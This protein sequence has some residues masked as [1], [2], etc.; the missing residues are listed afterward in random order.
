MKSASDPNL[1]SGLIMRL[2]SGFYVVET[3]QGLV[4][5]KVRGLLKRGPRIGDIVAV[6]DQVKIKL[7]PEG[8]GVIEEVEERHH[9]LERLAPTARGVYRQILLANPEQ[10][11]LVFACTQPSPSLR[12]LDRFLVIAEKQEIPPLIVV[13][14]VDLLGFEAA[15]N[16]FSI[17]GDIGYRVLFA[18]AL[19]GMGI[20]KLRQFL[21]GKLTALAGPSGAGKSSLL[22]AVQ[23]DLGLAVSKISKST[24]KG[25]HTTV[26]RQLFPLD[27]GGYVADMP[28]L[29]ALSLWD[30]EPEEIDGYFPELRPLVQFCR[31]NDCTHEPGE[32]GC[33]VHTAVEEGKVDPARYKSYLYLRAGDEEE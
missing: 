25:R 27:G 22:N 10:V 15:Q 14:K 33:A 6:G 20:E 21:S 29:R 19:S 8:S 12:M 9:S 18:S 31:F 1:L 28:G 3:E 4:T 30:T 16:L 17:Y 2:Q 5:C 23:P 11:V 24:S 7:L 32:P 13:N 26:V